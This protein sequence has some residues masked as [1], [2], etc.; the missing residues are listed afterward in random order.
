[1]MEN[2][3]PPPA[4]PT[5][6]FGACDRHNLGDLLF[7]HVAA[8]LLGGQ[9]LRYAGLAGRDLHR[10]GGHRLQGVAEVARQ[11]GRQPVNLMH[12]GGELLTCEAWQAAAML[13]PP[14]Q[15]PAWLAYLERHPEA[16]LQWARDRL[17]LDARAPYLLA[18]GMFPGAQR[19]IYNA[20]GGVE[21]AACEAGMRAEVLAKLASADYVSVRDRVTQAQL[22]AA[23]IAAALSPDPAVMVAELFGARIRQR[24][25]SGRVA[26][27]L[28]GFPGGYLALQFSADFGDDATLCE[29]AAQLDLAARATGCGVVLFRAGAAPWHDDIGCYR[30]LAARMR[31]PVACFGSLNIW[32]ICAL[33]AQS[34]LY[35]G[36]SLHGRIVAAAFGVP[37]L[38]L[39]HPDPA[40]RPGKLAAYIQDWEEADFPAATEVQDMAQGIRQTLGAVPRRLR[41]QA[42]HLAARYRQQFGAI[43]SLLA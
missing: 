16:R 38:S 7:P 27:R 35:C 42:E 9:Q 40:A 33:L 26:R 11:L 37:R 12:V 34:R 13:L 21:L 30:R 43:R 25:R 23:G 18:R 28:P 8:A 2:P 41:L 14:R 36:S 24:A 10:H 17:G 29:M 3:R 6:L 15:A 20:V 32:D 19:V 1:M 22:A 4:V 31:S 5:L 39:L